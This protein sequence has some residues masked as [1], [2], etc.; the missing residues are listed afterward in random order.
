MFTGI[1]A[2]VG[3]IAATEPK[4]GDLRIQVQVGKLDMSDVALGDSI[5]TNGV[6]LTVIE[7]DAQHYWADV[8]NE[9]LEHT[10]LAALKVGSAVNLEKALTPNTRL[11]GHWV[12][13]HVDGVGEVIER[14]DDARSVRFSLR[15]P[16][17]LAKYIAQK[18]SI[19]V[20]GA[21]LT[22]NAVDGAVFELN[23]VPHTIAETIIGSYVSGSPVNIEVDILARHLERLMLGDAAAESDG[24]NDSRQGVTAALL[25]SSGYPAPHS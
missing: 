18:G 19:C 7:M 2:A 10:T 14:H 12:A 1:I 25:A 9:T 17:A 8:S 16:A 22:V 20:D 11:G 23:I 15:A 13:G 4:G 5:A 3:H 24:E 6:C 21:S